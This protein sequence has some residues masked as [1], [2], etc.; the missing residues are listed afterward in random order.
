MMND[1]VDGASPSIPLYPFTAIVGQEAMKKALVLNLIQPALG[2]VL[3]RGERGTA[4]STAV[5]ALAALS[6]SPAGTGAEGGL[7]LK[8]VELPV[9]ATED[10]VVGTLDLEQALKSGRRAFQPGL[11]QEAHGNILYVDE[12]NLLPDHLVDLLLDVAAMGVNR[13][14]REGI[15]HAHPARFILVGSMNPEEGELRPQLLDRF[16]LFVDVEAETDLA[17]RVE[18]LRRR[19]EFEAD[20]EGFRRRFQAEEEALAGIIRRARAAL[21]RIAPDD[22]LLR[23]A[24]DLALRMEVD[25]HRGE[26]ALVKTAC[27]LAAWEWAA[28]AGSGGDG[29]APR[30]E[31]RHLLEAA[32]WIFSHRM[33]KGVLDASRLPAEPLESWREDY[34]PASAPPV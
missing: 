4:K 20:P 5:R 7:R 22:A 32:P 14:E 24:A 17:R 26:I 13:V 33:R 10:R 29:A 25:G 12:I 9:S 23:S 34:L 18:I 8:V 1:D 6:T 21:P 3:I 31:P 16:A 28:A 30:A 11:L 2:G 15:S 19:L 27:S